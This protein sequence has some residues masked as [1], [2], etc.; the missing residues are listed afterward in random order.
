MPTKSTWSLFATPKSL[1][2]AILVAA[3]SFALSLPFT[4]GFVGDSANRIRREHGL[5]LPASASEFECK[6]DAWI[7]FLD[8]GAASAFEISTNDLAAFVAQ[9]RLNPSGTKF[10]PGNSQYRLHAPWRAGNSLATY[11]CDSPTGDWLYVEIWP[12]NAFRVG[13]CLYTDWN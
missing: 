1:K 4:C 8:R 9:L 11:S 7:S 3:C 12:I 2:N 5:Q 10:I 6:G 13:V